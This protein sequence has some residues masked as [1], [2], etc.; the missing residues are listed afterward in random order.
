MKDSRA[1]KPFSATPISLSVKKQP[2][3]TQEL[4]NFAT[5]GF[6]KKL[7]EMSKD[8]DGKTATKVESLLFDALAKYEEYLSTPEG[9][10][11]PYPRNM[12]VP[13][14]VSFTNA[15]A[16]K[17]LIYGISSQDW[18]LFTKGSDAKKETNGFFQTREGFRIP[19]TEAYRFEVVFHG[20]LFC[21][22]RRSQFCVTGTAV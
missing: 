16:R 8:V 18:E 7:N 13:N 22:S 15:N 17:V 6:N 21:K 4:V 2:E 9:K 12:I 20:Q 1:P 19:D 14:T 3:Q 5:L 10:A 11:N